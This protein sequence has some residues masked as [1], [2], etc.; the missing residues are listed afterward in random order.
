MT[1][2]RGELRHTGTLLIEVAH[3]QNPEI[4]FVLILD[5]SPLITQ[6]ATL[7][8]A[9]RSVDHEVVTNVG[10]SLASMSIANQLDA[11]SAR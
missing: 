8:D 11:R 2:K 4:A 6:I 10:P 9:S 7:P 3:A 5:V 1:V